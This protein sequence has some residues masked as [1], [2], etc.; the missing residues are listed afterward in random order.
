M[1]AMPPST[2]VP[3]ARLSAIT[4][5]PDPPAEKR[6]VVV[7]LGQEGHDI[8]RRRKRDLA[9]LYRWTLGSTE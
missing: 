9:G 7:E 4:Y 2:A 3:A 6:G 5:C 1:P 8:S